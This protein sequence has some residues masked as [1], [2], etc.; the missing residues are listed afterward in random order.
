MK[1][2]ILDSEITF[3]VLNLVGGSLDAIE[4][5]KW[6]AGREFDFG[7]IVCKIVS[8]DVLSWTLNFLMVKISAIKPVD[9]IVQTWRWLWFR[10][11]SIL[12]VENIFIPAIQL[13]H[14][15]LSASSAAQH[16]MQPKMKEMSMLNCKEFFF[17][18][19]PNKK[20][21]HTFFWRFA[22]RRVPFN[23]STA[24]RSR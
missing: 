11:F 14:L 4:T 10:W 17:S 23:A 22:A 12:L 8:L 13:A 24:R 20:W 7:Y 5:I 16:Q 3:I 19:F 21:I 9:N 2:L 18:I 1:A 6:L 15:Y